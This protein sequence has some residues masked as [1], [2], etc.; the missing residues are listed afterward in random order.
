MPLASLPRVAG[1]APSSPRARF[2]TW[3]WVLLAAVAACTPAPYRGEAPPMLQPLPLQPDLDAE[4]ALR[5]APVVLAT[6]PDAGAEAPIAV[7]LAQALR[8]TALAHPRIRAALEQVMQ[9]RGDHTTAS[10]LPNPSFS[11]SLTLLPLPGQSF[12]ATTRQGGPPQLDLGLGVLID[13]W[14]FGKRDLAQRVAAF[15]VDVALAEYADRARVLLQETV[16]AFHDALLARELLQL[17]RADRDQWQRVEQVTNQRVELGGAGRHELDRV[18]AELGAATRRALRAEADHGNALSR[19]RALLGGVP[20]AE[21]AV[22]EGSLSALPTGEPP[23]LAEV[24]ALAEQQRPDLEVARRRVRRAQ[25]AVLFERRMAWPVLGVAGGYTRQYQRRAIGF[26]DVS[27]IGGGFDLSLPLF[28]RN[29][30]NILFAE[31]QLRE[32]ELLLQAARVELRA[33]VEQALRGYR[34]AMAVERTVREQELE[35]ATRQRDV[36]EAAYRLGER[37]VLEVLDAQGAL[38][39]ALREHWSARAELLGTLYRL[40]TVVGTPV[41]GRP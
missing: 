24:L 34:T 4:G 30:G 2:G 28:D 36:V 22:P 27:A 17:A 23:P 19:F 18:R 29:Q 35:P 8:V 5:P 16:V 31:S 7:P 13:G 25:A 21:R 9:A 1:Q 41:L 6:T 33:E 15:E 37:S 12:N 14:L 11:G 26:P 40:D 3:R 10:L 20:G 38:R 39:N 32:A